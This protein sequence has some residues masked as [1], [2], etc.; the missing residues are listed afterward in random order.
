MTLIKRGL[1]DSTKMGVSI[2]SMGY[3][4]LRKKYG[5]KGMRHTGKIPTCI[6]PQ[7]IIIKILRAT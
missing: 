2:K 7:S 1:R 6:W 3:I 5:L 4:Q